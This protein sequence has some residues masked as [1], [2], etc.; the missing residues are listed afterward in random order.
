MTLTK[1]MVIFIT[2]SKE[3]NMS[4]AQ[5]QEFKERL[6][7]LKNLPLQSIERIRGLRQLDADITA[8]SK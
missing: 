3:R 5:L 1:F 6:E 7:A 2:A 4:M 8:V